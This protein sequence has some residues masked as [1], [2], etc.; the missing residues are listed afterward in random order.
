MTLSALPAG[1]LAPALGLLNPAT[2]TRDLLGVRMSYREFAPVRTARI[3]GSITGERIRLRWAEAPA[4][5]AYQTFA[6]RSTSDEPMKSGE[7][8]AYPPWIGDATIVE[9][10]AGRLLAQTTGDAVRYH[11]DEVTISS[12]WSAVHQG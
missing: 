8:P 1:I 6:I 12:L 7:Q 5:I 4:P 11:K 9:P 10:I 3:I 2:A